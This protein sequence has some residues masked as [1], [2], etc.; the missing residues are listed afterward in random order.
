MRGSSSLHVNSPGGVRE[1][2]GHSAYE[3]GGMFVVSLKGV[4]FGIL[5]SLRVFC[6][7]RHHI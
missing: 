5:V 3:R 1:G 6:A 2:G 4:N 7:K